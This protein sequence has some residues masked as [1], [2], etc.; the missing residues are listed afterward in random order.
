MFRS[1][2]RKLGVCRFLYARLFSLCL[3]LTPVRI[4]YTRCLKYRTLARKQSEDVNLSFPRKPITIPRSFDERERNLSVMLR[5][6]KVSLSSLSPF[7]TFDLS[8]S[9]RCTSMKIPTYAFAILGSDSWRSGLEIKSERRRRKELI[10]RPAR[11]H[12]GEKEGRA[13]GTREKV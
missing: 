8:I 12:R 2:L 3:S 5:T 10:S 1:V 7:V 4:D 13:V 11:Y 6:K 9:R